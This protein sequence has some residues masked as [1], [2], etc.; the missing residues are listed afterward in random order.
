MLISDNSEPCTIAIR[1][2]ARAVVWMSG[3]LSFQNPV[4]VRI[5]QPNRTQ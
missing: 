5:A 1:V 4:E 3:S 2:F